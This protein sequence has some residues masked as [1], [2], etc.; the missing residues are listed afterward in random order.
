MEEESINESTRILK[1]EK[2]KIKYVITFIIVNKGNLWVRTLYCKDCPNITYLIKKE[3]K[4]KLQLVFFLKIDK[5]YQ[6]CMK[7]QILL[8]KNLLIILINW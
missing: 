7:I 2:I 8:I 1:E 3:N 4:K 6:K 5:F